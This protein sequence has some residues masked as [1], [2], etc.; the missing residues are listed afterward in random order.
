MAVRSGGLLVLAV[1]F[2]FLVRDASTRK[3]LG[4]RMIWK[5]VSRLGR[6]SVGRAKHVLASKHVHL[7]R[8]SREV[9]Q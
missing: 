4:G 6:L 1:I 3:W 9:V 8:P 5:Q 7:L 2:T